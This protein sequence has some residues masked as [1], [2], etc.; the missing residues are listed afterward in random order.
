MILNRFTTALVIAVLSVGGATIAGCG[1]SDVP[2]V[3]QAKEQAQK[4]LDSAQ[5]EADKAIADAHGATLALGRSARLGGLRCVERHSAWIR[6][7]LMRND[8]HP[9]AFR[10]DFE[11]VRGGCTERVSGRQNDLLAPV[12]VV[13]GQ[14]GDAGR[15][16]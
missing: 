3:S 16:A 2:G 7:R 14:F 11:L 10:P 15:L 13:L 4:A 1:A 9:D 6:A 8:G 5:K 12:L